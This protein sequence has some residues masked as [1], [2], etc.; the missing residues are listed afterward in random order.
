MK[1]RGLLLGLGAALAAPAVI[2][3]PWLLMPVREIPDRYL[4][5][6]GPGEVLSGKQ[7]RTP[8]HVLLEDGAAILRCEIDCTGF[9]RGLD[10]HGH[11]S[12]AAISVA[13]AGQSSEIL[14]LSF[15]YPA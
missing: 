1:R 8:W 15:P 11:N 4:I 6:V 7:I 12:R 2:R 5:R 10:L 3:T 9:E 13:R 14:I